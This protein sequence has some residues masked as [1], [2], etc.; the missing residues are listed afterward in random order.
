MPQ[1]RQHWPLLTGILLVF[2]LGFVASEC[3]A[4][5]RAAA[6]SVTVGAIDDGAKGGPAVLTTAVVPLR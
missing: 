1:V 6:E 2:M 5:Q 4:Q 3:R